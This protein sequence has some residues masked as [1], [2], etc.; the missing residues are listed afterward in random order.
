MKSVRIP[1]LFES[2]PSITCWITRNKS[3]CSEFYYMLFIS[4]SPISNSSHSIN[5]V[6]N[7][8]FIFTCCHLRNLL[9]Y[10]GF[11]LD[12]LWT[13]KLEFSHWYRVMANST[14]VN[15]SP[16][17]DTYTV[18]DQFQT[19]WRSDCFVTLQYMI[20]DGTISRCCGLLTKG[21]TFSHKTPAKIQNKGKSDSEILMSFGLEEN[22][23]D[24]LWSK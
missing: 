18:G 13:D 24:I 14:A 22:K 4:I 11:I 9:E 6:P 12:S 21:I 19:E 1:E 16:R 20:N 7:L 10:S 23:T 2:G 3:L 15:S 8:M 5:N 17:Y